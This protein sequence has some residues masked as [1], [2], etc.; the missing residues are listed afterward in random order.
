MKKILFTFFIFLISIYNVNAATSKEEVRFSKCVDGDTAKFIIN[1][2]V[3]T[4][5]FL[6][7][8]T[9]ETVHPSVEEE[10]Y[11]KTASEYTCDKLTNAKKIILEYEES[12]KK[13]K[14]DRLLA[15]VWV[16]NELLQDNLIKLGFAEVAYI[17]GDYKY[18]D[19]LKDHQA[20]AEINMTGIWGIPETV[21]K[22]NEKNTSNDSKSNEETTKYEEI[23]TIV[24]LICAII[25]FIFNPTFRKKTTTKIKKQVKKELNDLL[26]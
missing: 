18:T 24:V 12:N 7:I 15:W 22:T 5:R 19:L 14:Y 9:P 20:T 1:G 10:A 16:D 4:V 2:E 21:N 6:A 3:K 11:G 13:D 26:K 25:A 17:Y 23:L 8:D